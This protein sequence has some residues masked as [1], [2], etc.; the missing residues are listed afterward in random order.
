MPFGKISLIKYFEH[1]E[2]DKTIICVYY[3][4]VCF[5]ESVMSEFWQ[6]FWQGILIWLLL[7]WVIKQLIISAVTNVVKEHIRQNPEEYGGEI[8]LTVEKHQG[9]LYCYRKDTNEFIGQGS[10][11][12]EI[13][14]IFTKRYPN[15]KGTIL[16]E[17]SAGL[18]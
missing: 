2:V 10:T 5:T 8:L 14:T 6:G 1:T 13:G 17:D 7:V 11:L 12:E 3:Y 15:N 9:I 16:K 4:K 18:L